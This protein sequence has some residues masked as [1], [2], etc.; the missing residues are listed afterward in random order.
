MKKN[1]FLIG[2][3]IFLIGS[4]VSNADDTWSDL[5][6]EPCY[7]PRMDGAYAELGLDPSTDKF[8]WGSARTMEICSSDLPG[9]PCQGCC[10]TVVYHEYYLD[11]GG[12]LMTARNYFV[13]I[14][15]IFGADNRCDGC[16]QEAFIKEFYSKLIEEKAKIPSFFEGLSD[17]LEYSLDGGWV[18]PIFTKG[19]C[20]SNNDNPCGDGEGC[21]YHM[22]IAQF[23][24]TTYDLDTLYW[25]DSFTP[26]SFGCDGD[27]CD[28]DCFDLARSQSLE[29]IFPD[30]LCGYYCARGEWER[31]TT[32][33]LRPFPG[34]LQCII[35]ITYMKRTTPPECGGYTD[36]RIEKVSL[37]SNCLG[38][39]ITDDELMT[40]AIE[41]TLKIEGMPLV[42]LYDSTESL[43]IAIANC[44]GYFQGYGDTVATYKPCDLETCCW[45]R[46]RFCQP[47]LGV[48]TREYIDGSMGSDSTCH[49]YFHECHYICGLL[50]TNGIDTLAR[51]ANPEFIYT[52]TGE[53]WTAPN[54][55]QG[56]TDL[57]IESG[58]IGQL[59]IEVVDV[60]GREI[61]SRKVEK[62]GFIEQIPLDLSN[63]G[64]GMYFYRVYLNKQM[65][66][67]G[68]I[69]ILK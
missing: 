11:Q 33:D 4:A 29:E 43:R 13:N 16:D 17:Y 9:D 50:Q 19:K 52:G 65:L 27:T 54:P 32:R 39:G 14:G 44:W 36:L 68:K 3:A 62:K 5:V 21:C 10:F 31:I 8:P 63:Y 69:S 6:G 60:N 55:T 35:Q 46:Y 28:V 48:Y 22:A 64:N 12:D 26:E 42:E 45:A 61:I 2:I 18:F 40:Y 67:S 58:D 37:G 59:E 51:T 1:L 53:S 15:G 34:C 20:M 49:V 66:T 38:C 25:D 56:I 7:I 47:S 24:T 30:T 23:D 57:F 41:H